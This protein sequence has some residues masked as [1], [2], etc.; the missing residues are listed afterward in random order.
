MFPYQSFKYGIWILNFYGVLIYPG[1]VMKQKYIKLCKYFNF[2]ALFVTYVPYISTFIDMSLNEEIVTSI[3]FVLAFLV[4]ITVTYQNQRSYQDILDKG[5]KMLTK[6]FQDNLFFLC[7]KIIL[8]LVFCIAL[9]IGS[10]IASV[11]SHPDLLRQEFAVYPIFP[12]DSSLVITLKSS[13]IMTLFCL[14]IE[15]QLLPGIIIVCLL[16]TTL[17]FVIKKLDNNLT[18]LLRKQGRHERQE[19]L[20]TFRQDLRQYWEIKRETDRCTKFFVLTW[21]VMMMS[22]M[23]TFLSKVAISQEQYVSV[24]ILFIC[25]NSYAL[26]HILIIIAMLLYCDHCDKRY[27]DLVHRASSV[28]GLKNIMPE[29]YGLDESILLHLEL[30]NRPDTRYTVYGMFTL[31]RCLLLSF[32]SAAINFYVMSIQ[33]RVAN[34]E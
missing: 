22:T 15:G 8:C 11:A 14:Y 17:V 20:N 23:L 32:I 6:S 27:E 12:D 16:N 9:F 31:D 10:L 2:V 3:I 7:R 18:N 21:F 28:V 24:K 29:D 30:S 34:K 33:I 13:C 26:M 4:M 25:N 5:F 1:A 19:S